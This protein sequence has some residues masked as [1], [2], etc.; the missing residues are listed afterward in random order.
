M[1]FI[2]QETVRKQQRQNQWWGDGGGSIFPWG[3]QGNMCYSPPASMT[4]R[5]ESVTFK[6]ASKV[7]I[8]E[9]EKKFRFHH[10]NTVSISWIWRFKGF[11]CHRKLDLSTFL[12]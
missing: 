12:E 5:L 11:Y 8:E 4:S 3:L 6:M 9:T 1:A 7:F 10:G 2:R